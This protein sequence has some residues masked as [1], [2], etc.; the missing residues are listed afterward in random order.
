MPLDRVSAVERLRIRDIP[1]E[2]RANLDKNAEYFDP[3]LVNAQTEGLFCSISSARNTA[4]R[5][6][7]AS[8][9]FP[10]PPPSLSPFHCAVETPDT[11]D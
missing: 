3:S 10:S 4:S 5:I 2:K 11:R 6:K 9:F 8:P 7:R 1:R